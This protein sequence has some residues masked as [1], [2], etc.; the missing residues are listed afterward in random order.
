[1]SF[2]GVIAHFCLCLNNILLS[3][4]T[5]VGDSDGHFGCFQILPIM[6]KAAVIVLGFH[7]CTLLIE[8]VFFL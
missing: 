1:M 7:K 6:N 4:Y 2:H 3:G 8:A 5:A